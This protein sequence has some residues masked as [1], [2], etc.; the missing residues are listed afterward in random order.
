MAPFNSRSFPDSLAL[1]KEG[2]LTI[3]TIDEVQKLHIRSVPLGSQPRRMCH[4]PTSHAFFVVTDDSGTPSPCQQSLLPL[5]TGAT[6]PAALLCTSL[7]SDRI[8][9]ERI[10]SLQQQITVQHW[11]LLFI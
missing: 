6:K 11:E 9:L 5:I 7:K 4:L 10:C 1:A 3:G 8:P 2:C